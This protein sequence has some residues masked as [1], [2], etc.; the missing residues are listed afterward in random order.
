VILCTVNPTRQL[1]VMD[2]YRLIV[3]V[4]N[5]TLGSYAQVIAIFKLFQVA[6]CDNQY[7]IFCPII[8]TMITN[9]ADDYACFIAMRHGVQYG[10]P[11]F[12]LASTYPGG[13]KTIKAASRVYDSKKHVIEGDTKLYRHE[14][15][16]LRNLM[17]KEEA[18]NSMA[19]NKDVAFDEAH[20]ISPPSPRPSVDDPNETQ[21]DEKGR[22]IIS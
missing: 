19:E 8:G 10:G 18:R 4:Y 17:E 2:L 3:Y 11:D 20:C 5:V 6:G 7:D 14:F 16:A 12:R 13:L 21:A 1:T 22:C 9:G 15:E